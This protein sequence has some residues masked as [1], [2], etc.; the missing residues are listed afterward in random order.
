MKVGGM[1]ARWQSN[2]KE[3]GGSQKHQ[4]ESGNFNNTGGLQITPSHPSKRSKGKE[5]TVII[6]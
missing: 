5:N 4:R 6:I 2:C 3:S 1:T